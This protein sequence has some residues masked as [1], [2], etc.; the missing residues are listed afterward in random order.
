MLKATSKKSRHL[1]RLV[2]RS[3]DPSRFKTMEVKTL[4]IGIWIN[5]FMGICG[6]IGYYS[7]DSYALALDGNFSFISAISFF[8]AMRIT[9]QKDFTSEK[10]PLG[11]Y[12][13]ENIYAFLQGILLIG[14]TVYAILQGAANIVQ[15]SKGELPEP[16]KIMPLM[17]YTVAMI[18][19]CIATWFFYSHQF[20]KTQKQSPILKAE[21]VAAFMDMLVTCGTGIALVAVAIVPATS[22][23]RFLNYI[24][25]SIIV[26]FISIFLL[27]EPIKIV[28]HSFFSLIGRTVQTPQLR[29]RVENIIVTSLDPIFR[30]EKFHIFHMGSCYEIEVTIRPVDDA[31][32]NLSLFRMSRQLME[33]R[34]REL[35]PSLV[36]EVIIA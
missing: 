32:M 35:F 1:S 2:V 16:L 25:D 33:T 26:I 22:P 28:A 31:L 15:Y 14:I 6:W 34:L 18:F 11:F 3:K 7:A 5:F 17:V 27:R 21:T 19:A 8:V 9:R 12:S 10:Y 20:E 29:H 13:V 23:F 36:L 24:G 4:K 30:L